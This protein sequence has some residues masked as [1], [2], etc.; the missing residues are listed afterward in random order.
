MLRVRGARAALRRSPDRAGPGRQLHAADV[1]PEAVRCARRNLAPVGGQAYLGDLYAALPATLRGRVDVLLANVPYVP[2]G[3]IAL[4]PPEARDHEPRVALDG[5]DDGLAV[6]RRVADGAAAWLAP[7]GHLLSEIGDR[8]AQ[9]A[10]AAFGHAGLMARVTGD[11]EA[12][13]IVGTRPH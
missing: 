6:L 3:E 7:G 11:D 2:T 4:M 5:G 12:T 9:A 8:Q 1:E 10:T 13:A